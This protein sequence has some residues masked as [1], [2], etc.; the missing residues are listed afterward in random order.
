[1]TAPC[2]APHGVIA[3]RLQSYFI[4]R[5]VRRNFFPQVS[6]VMWPSPLASS[7]IMRIFLGVAA[8]GSSTPNRGGVKLSSKR[9]SRH[10]SRGNVSTHR[11]EERHGPHDDILPP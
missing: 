7:S 3:G 8:S 4:A 11:Q 1:M 5:K 10:P 2:Q 9:G 6:T